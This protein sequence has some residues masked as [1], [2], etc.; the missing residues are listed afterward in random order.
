MPW[1]EHMPSAQWSVRSGIA[2]GAYLLG[3]FTPGYYLVRLR[4]GQDIREEGSGSVG[5]KNVG[6]LLGWRGFMLTVFG[7]IGKGMLAVWATRRF[8][9]SDGM[10]AIAMVAVAVGHVWPAQLR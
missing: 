7:D 6:R 10:A 9:N 3:C 1:M 8:T 4:T 5:A 2:L